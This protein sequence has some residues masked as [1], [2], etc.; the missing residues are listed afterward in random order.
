MNPGELLRLSNSSLDEAKKQLIE[1]LIGYNTFFNSTP[2]ACPVHPRFGKLNIQSGKSSI[3]NTLSIT[4]D[5]LGFGNKKA[6]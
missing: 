1:N 6:L 5:S 2:D 4:S 3:Q